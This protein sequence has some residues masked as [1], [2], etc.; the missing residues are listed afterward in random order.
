[1]NFR[2]KEDSNHSGI[3]YANIHSENSNTKKSDNNTGNF[4]N[5][6]KEK[7]KYFLENKKVGRFMNKYYGW[8]PF[9]SAIRYTNKKMK[10]DYKKYGFIVPTLKLFGHT[11]YAIGW[12]LG[13]YALPFILANGVN[14]QNNLEHKLEHNPKQEIHSPKEEDSQEKLYSHTN[15]FTNSKIG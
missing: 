3:N 1:M 11:I 10:S 2:N 13:K 8:F 5:K 15:Y 7:G 6:T 14:N 12:S 4:W 9:G